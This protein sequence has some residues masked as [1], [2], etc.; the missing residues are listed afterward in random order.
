MLNSGSDHDW[1]VE[2]NDDV[3]KVKFINSFASVQ[4]TSLA[5]WFWGFTELEEIEGIEYLNTSAVTTMNAAFAY[6]THLEEININKFDTGKLTNTT[7]MFS[8]CSRLKTIYCSNTWDVET[9]GS[10][11]F[12]CPALVGAVSYDSDRQH[13]GRR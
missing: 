5:S 6:C 11:F 2:C 1:R 12:M 13:T 7:T 10:M 3:A 4:P 9:S 8:G